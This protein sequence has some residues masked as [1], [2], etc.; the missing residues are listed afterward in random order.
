MYLTEL[1]RDVHELMQL[2]VLADTGVDKPPT[3]EN[4]D[5]TRS[6]DATAEFLRHIA[7]TLRRKST[8][9]GR[10]LDRF[11]VQTQ[12]R[13]QLG[14]G[15]GIPDHTP[16]NFTGAQTGTCYAAM[17]DLSFHLFNIAGFLTNVTTPRL[18]TT[19]T[20]AT[21]T[22]T[23]AS[24][25]TLSGETSDWPEVD[26]TTTNFTGV[27]VTQPSPLCSCPTLP[28]PPTA[29]PVYVAPILRASDLLPVE[30]DVRGYLERSNTVAECLS[31][32][33]EVLSKTIEWRKATGAAT[34]LLR[35][36]VGQGDTFD[37]ADEVEVIEQD[38]RNV[39][40]LYY[41]YAYAQVSCCPT[42][43]ESENTNS[44][45]RNFPPR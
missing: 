43:R 33:G 15:S 35:L 10:T 22:T 41:R 36:D 19:T 31:G 6:D 29:A 16:V 24:T 26:N 45:L 32:Y 8:L 23:P 25:T 9:A 5:S 39:E 42:P 1:D 13:S 11:I 21:T 17:K 2:M 7:D 20:A 34:R 4:G 37:F 18:Q 14:D 38:E 30:P 27:S 28:P 12:N 44:T 40:R 3:E